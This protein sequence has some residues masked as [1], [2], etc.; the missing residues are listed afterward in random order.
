MRLPHGQIS[1]GA[2]HRIQILKGHGSL[3][4]VVEFFQCRQVSSI[5]FW[6][7]DTNVIQISLHV[8][9]FSEIKLV[10]LMVNNCG[11]MIVHV[12]NDTKLK[13]LLLGCIT[14]AR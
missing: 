12:L 4:A 7:S 13:D 11:K 14:C 10:R 6:A 9:S 8:H 1:D 3:V 2:A 5:W